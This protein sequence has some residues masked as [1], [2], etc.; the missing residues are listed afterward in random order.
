MVINNT[1]LYSETFKIIKNFIKTQ[2]T[3][4]RNRSKGNWV[5]DS[6]PLITDKG[7]EGYP[8]VII[9]N[10]VSDDGSTRG[11]DGQTVN[12]TFR[13]QLR[14]MS[15]QGTEIDSISDQIAQKFREGPSLVNPPVIHY[16]MNDNDANKIVLDAVGNNNGTSVNNTDTMDVEGKINNALEF[17]GVDDTV[18]MPNDVSLSSDNSFTISVWSNHAPVT[19]KTSSIISLRPSALRGIGIDVNPNGDTIFKMRDDTEASE[20]AFTTIPTGWHHYVATYNADT[21]TMEAFFDGVS[22]GT[23]T[24]TTTII[25]TENNIGSDNI[26]AGSQADFVGK[27]DD[28]RIYNSG[29]SLQDILKIYNS[30]LGTEEISPVITADQLSEFPE[31]ELASSP[32]DWNLDINGKKVLFRNIGLIFRKRI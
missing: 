14:V 28:V 9:R 24:H 25:S 27:I 8:F 23:T 16:H 19:G 32:I 11:K 13:I 7:F 4:P 17:N 21:N 18:T 1:N 22:Q 26:I 3:D 20:V 31:R 29:L 10:D 2:I 15:D 5:H 12:E 30:G 6:M